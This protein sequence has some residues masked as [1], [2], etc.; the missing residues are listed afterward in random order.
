MPYGQG[1]PRSTQE[2]NGSI[3][4]RHGGEVNQSRASFDPFRE[5]FVMVRKHDVHLNREK[6]FFFCRW[7]GQVPQVYDHL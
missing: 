3:C 4:G 1:V 7:R 2:H 6:C 5:L